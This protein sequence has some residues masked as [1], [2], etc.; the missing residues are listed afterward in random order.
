MMFDIIIEKTQDMLFKN[1]HRQI[2]KNNN[3]ILNEIAFIH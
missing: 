2:K 3:Q 1:K